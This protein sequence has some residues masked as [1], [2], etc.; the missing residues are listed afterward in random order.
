MASL[1][2]GEIDSQRAL[3][4]YVVAGLKLGCRVRIVGGA[5]AL[6]SLEPNESARFGGGLCAGDSRRAEEQ[7]QECRSNH[8]YFRAFVGLRHVSDGYATG[9]P[10]LENCQWYESPAT[11]DS[12]KTP[13]A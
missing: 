10:T 7:K 12:R 11:A 4:K 2:I 6:A 1:A 13:L 5:M 8:S 9:I 3:N